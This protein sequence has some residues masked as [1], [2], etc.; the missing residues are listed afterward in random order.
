MLRLRAGALGAYNS[1][2]GLDRLRRDCLESEE[3]TNREYIRD[4]LS[5]ILL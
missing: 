5:G 2:R 4:D 1:M 3:V